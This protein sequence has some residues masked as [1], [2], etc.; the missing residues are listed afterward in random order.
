[1][2]LNQYLI[3]K[4]KCLTNCFNMLKNFDLNSSIELPI[5]TAQRKPEVIKGFDSGTTI[6]L[7]E[8]NGKDEFKVAG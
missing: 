7:P 6:E 5:T 8:M 4:K 1:M 2:V 3:M